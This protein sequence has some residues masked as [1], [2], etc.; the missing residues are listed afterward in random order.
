MK[1]E[2]SCVQTERK[3]MFSKPVYFL[4][5]SYQNDCMCLTPRI[6][7]RKINLG[8]HLNADTLIVTIEKWECTVERGTMS[9]SYPGVST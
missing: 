2:I 7:N 1:K 3:Y 4:T 9:A 5:S 8:K 6:C